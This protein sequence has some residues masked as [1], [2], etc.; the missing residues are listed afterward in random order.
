MLSA[1]LNDGLIYLTGLPVLS[2]WLIFLA[3]NVIITV[4]V[5]LIGRQ[6]QQKFSVDT[7][8][9]Y[10]YTRREWQLCGLTNILN[11]LITYAGFWLWKSGFIKIETDVSLAIFLDFLFLFFGMDILMFVFHYMIHQTFLYQS[12]HRLHHLAVHP[13]PIDLF[14]LHP[15]ETLSFGGLWLFMLWLYPFN[16]CA[17]V[18]YLMINIIFGLTGHLGIEPL[19]ANIRNLP[20]IKYLGT[21][22]FHHNHHQQE[23]YNFGFYTSLWDR[24]FGTYKA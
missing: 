24:L 20:F 11:T 1:N 16:I 23:R 2:L 10:S 6:L 3:E 9:N 4:L 18:I 7:L 22:T 17:V 5:L 8:I 13:K 19:P 12:V 21:S 14:I 15:L